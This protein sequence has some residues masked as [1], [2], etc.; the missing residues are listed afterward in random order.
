MLLPKQET[1]DF[2]GEITVE[3]LSTWYNVF[4][5]NTL[6]ESHIFQCCIYVN[7]LL[8]LCYKGSLVI[9][10]SKVIFSSCSL[11][12]QSADFNFCPWRRTMVKPTPFEDW[13]YEYDTFLLHERTKQKGQNSAWQSLLSRF[14]KLFFTLY[15]DLN[16][17][18]KS[19]M[20]CDS[21]WWDLFIHMQN[22]EID[23]KKKCHKFILWNHVVDVNN[24][25]KYRCV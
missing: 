18:R 19:L 8:Y 11:R 9:C 13:R 14:G 2:I 20:H 23:K 24:C 12:L 4:Q 5:S 25:I 3:K 15:S 21:D 6:L 1:K 17:K 22:F 10:T 7:E 16:T